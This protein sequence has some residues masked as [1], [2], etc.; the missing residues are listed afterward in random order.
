MSRPS[1]L[2]VS[3][4]LLWNATEFTVT[5]APLVETHS[6]QQHLLVNHHELTLTCFGEFLPEVTKFLLIRL[7]GFFPAAIVFLVVFEVSTV[8][9]VW[10]TMVMSV[11]GGRCPGRRRRFGPRLLLGWRIFTTTTTS[12]TRGFLLLLGLFPLGGGCHQRRWQFTRCTTTTVIGGSGCCGH[13]R[14]S[15]S[16]RLFHPS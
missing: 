4:H 10:M 12:I 2:P 6:L 13:G 8:S 3:R 15:S 7:D 1:P 11:L 9:S 16:S 14:S 5:G